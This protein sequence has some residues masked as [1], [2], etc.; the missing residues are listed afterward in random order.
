[1]T[2]SW[3]DERPDGEPDP[4]PAGHLSEPCA[5]REDEAARLDRRLARAREADDVPPARVRFDPGGGAVL[6]DLGPR[7]D[8]GAAEGQA[9]QVGARETVDGTVAR[10]NR[11][12]R[13]A[14]LDPAGRFEAE[15]PDRRPRLAPGAHPLFE[16]GGFALAVKARDRPSQAVTP[17]S[18][19]SHSRAD[20]H[21]RWASRA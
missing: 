16:Q 8:E 20:V 11:P 4:E 6:E 5:P 15:K 2:A 1:M 13:E 7:P 17:T 12:S 3:F 14:G 10:E 19:P 21:I 18:W 9:G